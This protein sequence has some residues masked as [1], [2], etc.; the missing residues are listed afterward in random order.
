MWACVSTCVCCGIV[1]AALGVTVLVMLASPDALFEELH[2]QNPDLADQGLT[3][4][5]IRTAS[6]IT[7]AVVLP[8]CMAAAG[9]AIQAFR[10]VRWGRLR[11]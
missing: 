7:A 11:C 3:D 1:V 10:R 6:L 5:E 2:R 9:F 8:W 4:G